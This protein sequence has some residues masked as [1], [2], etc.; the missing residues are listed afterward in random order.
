MCAGNVR[1]RPAVGANVSNVTNHAPSNF[2]RVSHVI[3]DFHTS[4]YAAYSQKIIYH[5]I[6][7]SGSNNKNTNV[8]AFMPLP[9]KR[10]IWLLSIR[11]ALKIQPKFGW[12]PVLDYL[13]G[14]FH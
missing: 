5:A 3:F 1:D 9:T 10:P 4:L 2:V 11:I 12:R 13:N 6:F 7:Q 14:Y 8:K